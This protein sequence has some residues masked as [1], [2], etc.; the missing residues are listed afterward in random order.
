MQLSNIPCP[1]LEKDF[2]DALRKKKN[3]SGALPCFGK[4]VNPGILPSFRNLTHPER[5]TAESLQAYLDSPTYGDDGL[6]YG[7]VVFSSLGESGELGAPGHWEYSIRLNVTVETSPYTGMPKTRP[8]DLGLRMEEA[9][10]YLDRGFSSIQLLLDRFI[11]GRR[12]AAANATALLAANGLGGLL[13]ANLTASAAEQLAEPLRYSPQSVEAV[14]MPVS[15]IV[16][17]GFYQLV[18]IAFPLIFIVAFLYTQKKVVNELI[19]EKETRVRESLRMGGVSSAAIMGSWYATYGLIFCILCAVFAAIAG[20]NVFPMSSGALIFAFFWLWCMSFLAFAFF[21]HCFFSHSRTGGIVSMMVMF[22]QWILYASQN[23][24]GPP[25][26]LVQQLLMLMPNAAFCAG[27]DMLAKFEAARVGAGWSNL[28]WPV[29]NSSFARVLLTMCVDIVLWTVL[30]WYL[31]AVLP[32][33][34]GVRQPWNFPFM[35]SYWLERPA[36]TDGDESSS[37][38]TCADADAAAAAACAGQATAEPVAEAIR[39]RSEASGTLVRIQRLR[40]EFSTPGGVKVAVAGLDLTMFEGQ[41]VSLL[42]HNGA[43]KSTT[44]N[45][46]TGMVA[47]TSGDAKICGYSLRTGLREIRTLMGTCPQHDVLWQELTVREHL[48]IFARLRG[49][50]EPAAIERRVVEMMKQVGLTE[51]AFTRAGSLSGGQRRKLS[52]CLA[53]IGEPRVAFLDEPTSGMDPFS[54]RFTWN[55]IR[56]VREG[57]VVV[58][59]THFMDEADILGD[60]IAIMAEGVLQCCGSSL[61]L[62]SRFG[63]GYRIT[64]A[65]RTSAIAG[66]CSPLPLAPAPAT[67][68]ASP[69]SA[70]EG[71]AEVVRRHLPEA[72]LLSD[73]AG[74][75]AMRLP[76]GAAGRFPALFA[77]LDARLD[78][79]GLVHYGLS[80]VTLEDVFLRV[81]S[82]EMDLQT[83]GVLAAAEPAAADD[84]LTT[85]ETGEGLASPSA[86]SSGTSSGVKAVAAAPALVAAAAREVALTADSRDRE[87]T[88]R[89]AARNGACRASLRHLHALFLKRAR[90]GRRDFK[91]VA[92]TVLLPV[93][94]LAFGLL[95]LERVADRHIPA[96]R[97]A[98]DEQYGQDF[99]LPYNATPGTLWP[100]VLADFPLGKPLQ[101]APQPA[102]PAGQAGEIF[103]QSYLN[104]VPVFKK[105]EERVTNMSKCWRQRNFCDRLPVWQTILSLQ[106]VGIDVG[107]ETDKDACINVVQNAC[108]DG[109]ARCVQ[110]CSAM[111]AG[112]SRG[113]CREECSTFCAQSGN[114]TKACGF[115]QPVPYLPSFTVSW[116]CPVQCANPWRPETCMPGTTCGPDKAVHA[117]APAATLNFEMS[118]YAQGQGTSRFDTRYGALLITEKADVGSV[119]TLLYN[120]SGV[121][122]VPTFANVATDALKRAVS[123]PD[124]SISVTNAPA[125]RARTERLDRVVSAI[126]DLMSTFVIIIAFSWIPAA[127]VAYVVREREV[128]H[129]SKHQQLISG[130]RLLA[131]W[132]SNLLWDLTVYTIPLSLSMLFLWACGISAFV[133]NG[134]MWAT[135]VTFTGYGLAITPFSYLLS[136]FFAKH[137]TAQ[138]I[139]LVINFVTGLLLMLTSYILSVIDSTKDV[140]RS[141]MWVYRLF[142]GFCLGHGLFEICMNSVAASQVHMKAQLDLLAWDVAGKDV[143]CLYVAAPLYFALAV[144]VDYLQSSPLAAYGK[145]SDPVMLGATAS[146]E[147]E[148]EVDEDVAAE[149]ERVLSGAADADVI[150]L[151]RLRKVY[152]TPEGRPKVAVRGLTF[153]LPRGECF[154]FLG[155]NGAGKTS[156][157]SMLTGA[158]LPSAGTAYLGGCDIVREQWQVRRLLGYCPQHDALL[159]RLTVREHLELFGRIKGIPRAELWTYCEAMMRDLDLKG[160]V[161]KLAMT[162]SGGNKRKLSLA[163]SLMGSPPLVLLDEPSTG[164]DPAARR[165]MWNVIS[166]KTVARRECSVMLT[167]H[168]MEEAEAL[169]S[170]IGIMVGGALR[171]LGSN[172]RLKSRFG[173]GYQLEARIRCPDSATA[174]GAASSWQLPARIEPGGLPALCARLGAP[175]RAAL[176]RAGCE[177]GHAIFEVFAREGSVGA[178]RFAEW[179]LLEDRLVA[180]DRFL[181]EHF[182]GTEALERHEGTVRYHLPAG[183]A[184]AE[185]FRGLEAARNELSV[186]EYGVCQTSLEQIFNT[187]AAQQREE[188]GSVRGLFVRGRSG[189]A[190]SESQLHS[191]VELA[192]GGAP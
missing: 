178:P 147:E 61:F 179:W 2:I 112:V 153:A 69:A 7:A 136:C 129:N 167:T 37:G 155:I 39:S 41:I 119:V 138:V 131:Y 163:I 18:S 9:D 175:E 32:K 5:Y 92:C 159:D 122:A 81:A 166:S 103:G 38:A 22:A 190:G 4:A 130:V 78:E 143:L 64:C 125:P 114:I 12:N 26:L 29:N 118:L 89:I 115:L 101:E 181:R 141:L 62:K 25:S 192:T 108:A 189:T 173:D 94:L 71:A 150:R 54:R 164:V 98:A 56:G 84:I 91:A 134:A 85:A 15:G 176:V 43:G 45:M 111:G 19:T 33:E 132:T 86:A 149:E 187:F 74:E 72:E 3:R 168:N 1:Q 171:C 68:D 14:P 65:R 23:K 127:I 100:D 11:V 172:Q 8:L 113:V 182:P 104:G 177:E 40:R 51:K 142:P 36:T 16:I 82:G 99:L 93:A 58:L 24:E 144:L 79:L 52:L 80:M 116:I 184:L 27:L 42:G 50:V 135:F 6:L 186:E 21:L 157:L 126:V 105:C 124:S 46:L 31:D 133:D 183:C 17:D 165:L 139:C 59:T 106:H 156:T 174:S 191:A 185:V 73:V 137:T 83:G 55:V 67:L 180:F 110:T 169:C 76:A 60:R 152:Q 53:L 107:C 48:A 44:I 120:T 88:A 123:G 63:A 102:L 96:V 35:P 117:A 10:V 30:A 95:M 34:Y 188:T 128:Q 90:Y 70:G 97:L 140:N 121:H 77:E 49:F 28:T 47:P 20:L 148:E 160:H 170:R 162:L 57:R 151:L 13:T 161:D 158:V 146:G 66:A 154:G 109:A 87:T 75:L 145:L